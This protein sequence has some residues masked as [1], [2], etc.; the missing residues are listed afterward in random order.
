[1]ILTLGVSSLVSRFCCNEGSVFRGI[2][3]NLEIQMEEN[4]LSDYN[5]N[6]RS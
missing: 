3:D 4:A 5:R 6:L 2:I 1:M